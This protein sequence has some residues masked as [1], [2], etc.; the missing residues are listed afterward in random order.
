M[1]YF[2]SV[3]F[4]K[5]IARGPTIGKIIRIITGIKPD[6]F[7]TKKYTAD[8]YKTNN[9]NVANNIILGVITEKCFIFY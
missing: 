7:L 4:F 5:I 6:L 8:K 1:S 3:K 9:V 2:L